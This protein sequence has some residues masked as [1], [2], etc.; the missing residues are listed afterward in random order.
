MILQW[1]SV[2]EMNAIRLSP[3]FELNVRS[4]RS[5]ECILQLRFTLISFIS[6]F[7]IG[8]QVNDSSGLLAEPLL[9]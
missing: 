8:S 9:P 7:K 4:R 1:R 5:Q 2:L 6:I 3:Y